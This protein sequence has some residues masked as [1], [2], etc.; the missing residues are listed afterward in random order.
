MTQPIDKPREF[1]V[2]NDRTDDNPFT[3]LAAYEEHRDSIRKL[4]PHSEKMTGPMEAIHVIEK[5]YA[6]MLEKR[7]ADMEE[8]WR[9]ASVGHERFTEMEEK[10]AKAIT[11]LKREC[12]CTGEKDWETGKEI[13][14][15]V[16]D[17]IK[18]LTAGCY[19]HET[20]SRNCPKHGGY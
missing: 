18:S 20:D 15:H 4:Y 10:L 11:A 16:C 5:S 9:E 1:W 19:C 2:A 6:D 14:C 3:S 17:I 12:M 13:P 7:L 8:A